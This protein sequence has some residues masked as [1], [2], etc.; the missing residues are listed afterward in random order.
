[1]MD[2]IEKYALLIAA[3]LVIAVNFYWLFKWR[4]PKDQKKKRNFWDYYFIWPLLLSRKEG[5]HY[6]KRDFSRRE[7]IGIISIVLLVL[8]ALIFVPGK[9]K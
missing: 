6:V 8:L 5:D 1:M 7:W 9:P 4:I 2:L 3:F